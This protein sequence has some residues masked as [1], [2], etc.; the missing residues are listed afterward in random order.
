MFLQYVDLGLCILRLTADCF[1]GGF[2]LQLFQVELGGVNNPDEPGGRQ[3]LAFFDACV[4][5]TPWHNNVQISKKKTEITK[6]IEE[7]V[8]EHNSDVAVNNQMSIFEAKGW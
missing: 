3:L 5:T 8:R 1:D 2:Q 6:G 7:L 4:A